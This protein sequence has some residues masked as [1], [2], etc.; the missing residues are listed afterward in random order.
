[1]SEACFTA[2]ATLHTQVKNLISEIPIICNEN[3]Q[4][5]HDAIVVFIGGVERTF[6]GLYNPLQPGKGMADL[7]LEAPNNL[8]T[9]SSPRIWPKPP[10]F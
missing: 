1:M 5:Q 3:G 2:H 7:L 9:I 10:R 8:N 6:K 4:Y